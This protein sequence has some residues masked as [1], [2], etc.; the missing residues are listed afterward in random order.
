MPGELTYAEVTPIRHKHKTFDWQNPRGRSGGK[1]DAVAQRHLREIAALR[2]RGGAVALAQCSWTRRCCVA[3]CADLPIENGGDKLGIEFY[4]L[5]EGGGRGHY[6]VAG[7]D[8]CDLAPSPRSRIWRSPAS[9]AAGDGVW[10]CSVRKV[11]RCRVCRRP[12][13]EKPSGSLQDGVERAADSLFAAVQ[14]CCPMNG[15]R[16]WSPRMR[17]LT[18]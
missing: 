13:T 10:S 1:A 14:Q 17:S 8:L 6:I 3:G 12:L 16:R 7:D 2:P 4:A 9:G 11:G 5:S 15:S 18:L